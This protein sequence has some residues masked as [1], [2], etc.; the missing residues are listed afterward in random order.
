MPA[1]GRPIGPLRA[2]VSDDSSWR[3]PT[4][5]CLHSVGPTARLASHARSHRPW[6]IRSASK[7]AKP[8]LIGAVRP[9]T[10]ART[11]RTPSILSTVAPSRTAGPLNS[12]TSSGEKGRPG[13]ACPCDPSVRFRGGLHAFGIGTPAADIQ[14]V[15][16]E[17]ERARIRRVLDGQAEHR[18]GERL[19]SQQV[20]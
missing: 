6:R 10:P 12:A 14:Q 1:H 15:I 4:L 7:Q 3:R 9:G 18:R 13:Q 16:R 2:Y 8:R 17:P 20:W 11:E 5:R 19:V